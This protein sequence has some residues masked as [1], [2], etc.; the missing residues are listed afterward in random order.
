MKII[1]QFIHEVWVLFK[2]LGMKYNICLFRDHYWMNV[3]YCDEDYCRGNRYI[4]SCTYK[5]CKRCGDKKDI[6]MD[7]KILPRRDK[8]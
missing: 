2:Q 1:F 7:Y 8:K 3:E 6:N 5:Q 4:T